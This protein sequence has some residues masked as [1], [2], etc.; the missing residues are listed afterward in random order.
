MSADAQVSSEPMADEPVSNFRLARIINEAG[1]FASC[2]E[3]Y[4]HI[5]GA[6]NTQAFKWGPSGKALGAPEGGRN[7]ASSSLQLAHAKERVLRF[8]T[9]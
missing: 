6:R 8:G 7:I 9:W 2:R 1:R 4:T 5:A 3:I